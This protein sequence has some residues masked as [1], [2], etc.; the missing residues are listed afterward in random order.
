MSEYESLTKSYKE[1]IHHLGEELVNCPKKCFGIV[2]ERTRGIIPR[3][4]ILETIDRDI[5]APGCIVIGINPGTASIEEMNTFRLHPKY[6]EF[7]SLWESKNSKWKYYP[8]LRN[9]INQIGIKGPILWTELVKCQSVKCQSNDKKQALPMDTY[10]TCMG[11]FLNME[12]KKSPPIWPLIGVGKDPYLALSYSY[13]NR[14]VIGVPHPT[15]SRGQF[16]AVRNE[17]ELLR[18]VGD[19]ISNNLNFNSFKAPWL[20]S[21]FN[22]QL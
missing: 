18:A 2:N 9:L 20:R 1:A 21:P 6:D 5:S 12:I 11:A 14:L 16:D 4:L 3:C 17:P 15:G 13:T 8:R 10:R 7:L 22:G 19:L